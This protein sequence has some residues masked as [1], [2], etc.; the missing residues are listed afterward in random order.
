MESGLEIAAGPGERADALRKLVVGTGITL[1]HKGA[2]TVI[3]HADGR[4]D[5]NVHGHPGLAT[6][7][8]GDVLKGAIAGLLAVELRRRTDEI[9]GTVGGDVEVPAPVFVV[10]VRCVDSL[11]G[12]VAT[13]PREQ[14]VAEYRVH[15]ILGLG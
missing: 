4:L 3:A 5:V 12:Q 1:V 10:G 7:G 8:S 13:E 11:G 14:G 15:R 6:A 2:P 9:R